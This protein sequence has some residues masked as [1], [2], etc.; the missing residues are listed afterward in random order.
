MPIELVTVPA[1]SLAA[2]ALAITSRCE[3]YARQAGAWRA[4]AGNPARF[5]DLDNDS[6]G[7]ACEPLFGLG[8]QHPA[9]PWLPGGAV[10]LRLGTGVDTWCLWHRRMALDLP[11]A[12]A[13]A[14]EHDP[15]VAIELAGLKADSELPSQQQPD[16][17][18][19]A[20]S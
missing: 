12:L 5:H 11:P 18:P 2:P 4:F 9:L 19:D 1:S 14:A 8:E 10:L 17:L 3:D 15:G 16:R 20:P 6:D 7:G 13:F